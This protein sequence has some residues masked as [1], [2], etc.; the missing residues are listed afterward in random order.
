MRLLRHACGARFG[1]PTANWMLEIGA[2]LMR[3]ETELLLKSR[4]VVPVR[5]LDAGFEF[6]YPEWRLAAENLYAQWKKL[7]ALGR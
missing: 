2:S 6:R 7:T 5:L 1:L 3:T 4:Q